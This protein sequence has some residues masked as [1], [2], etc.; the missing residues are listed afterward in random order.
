MRLLGVSVVTG[1]CQGMFVLIRKLSQGVDVMWRCSMATVPL[2]Q[3]LSSV[4]P[5]RALRNLMMMSSV[6]MM[7]QQ[8]ERT[9][10]R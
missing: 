9:V 6:K 10:Q 8:E 1:E 7:M 3:T 2:S 5:S 4:A